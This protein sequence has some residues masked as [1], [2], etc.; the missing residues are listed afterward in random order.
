[1]FS[2][3]GTRVASRALTKITKSLPPHPSHNTKTHTHTT[4]KPTISAD[5]LYDGPNGAWS[6]ALTISK[7]CLTLRSMLA[8]N[9][10]R[11]RPAGDADYCRRVGGRSPKLTQWRFDDDS[12]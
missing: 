1:V 9:A 7:L 11:S 2:L 3:F 4:Q 10:D 6:P 12:V 8:S 5:I